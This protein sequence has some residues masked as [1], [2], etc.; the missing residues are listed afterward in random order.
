MPPKVAAEFILK[1]VL[2]FK[3]LPKG[4]KIF[5]EPQIKTLKDN[6]WTTS[7]QRFLQPFVL[8]AP[9]ADP[10]LPPL[11]RI[12]PRESGGK[13]SKSDT[14]LVKS[15]LAFGTGSH[16]TTQMAAELLWEALVRTKVGHKR[17]N[18]LDV[19]CGTGVLAMV[20]KRLKSP[21]VV[22]VDNDP[23]ALKMARENFVRN[24]L[25]ISRRDDLRKAQGRY[26][27][28]VANI[29]LS[30]LTELR[31]DLELKLLPRGLLIVSGL[32]YRDVPSLLKA[33]S[34]FKLVKR[35]NRKGWAAL[36]LRKK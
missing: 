5:Y 26:D 25:K 35:K 9:T 15:S 24:G 2:S 30:T 6:S 29:L 31:R 4:E 16:P 20:A 34:K 18:V 33:Y 21:S 10:R 36:L 17:G 1:R 12:D 19:G 28:V 3:A 7:Y 8:K 14:L 11:L 32:L 22:A 13:A 23:V 27:V